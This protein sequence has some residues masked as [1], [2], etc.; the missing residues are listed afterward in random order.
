MFAASASNC[1]GLYSKVFPLGSHLFQKWGESA[2]N[3]FIPTANTLL[4]TDDIY[5][6]NSNGARRQWTGLVGARDRSHFRQTFLP[7]PQ[8]SLSF[9]HP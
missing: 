3:V 2:E 9:T 1:Q 5:S 6:V 4:N 7:P 8:H